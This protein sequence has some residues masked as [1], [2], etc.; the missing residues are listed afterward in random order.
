MNAFLTKRALHSI[1][2]LVLLLASVFFL[3]RLTGD[4]T[5]LYMPTDAPMSERIKFAER[6]GLN[7][8]VIVQ[9]GRYLR[10]LLELDFGNSLR[11]QRPAIDAVF[12]AFPQ[13]LKLAFT[14]ML[15]AVTLAV[16]VG[17]LAATRPNGI[18]D[19]VAST[20]SL[21]AASAPDFWVAITAVMAF[22]LA[23]GWLP[24]SGTGTALHWVLPVGVLALRP[25]GLLL[26]V[27]RAS[28]IA[29]LSSAYIKT[30]RAK[31]L[32]A[33]T[34]VFRHA[35]RN[36]LL[37]TITVTGDLLVNIVNGAVVVETVFGWPGVGRLLLG[38]IVDRDFPLVQ[39]AIL[40]IACAIFLI[41]LI[42]D[43][44]YALAD[45]RIRYE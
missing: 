45:P 6:H 25:F 11:Q 39:A 24:T 2:A 29:A 18:F 9:F 14:S 30:A 22:S 31:G 40:V 13:T 19:R 35:L 8:P 27:V 7:D 17:A 38:A 41:N 34:I 26:Q 43:I 1:L 3:S 12:E 10:S 15:I 42:I 16:V 37:P 4:P 28:M 32:R 44:L 36:S 5:Q 20:V 21:L 33:R 23:F